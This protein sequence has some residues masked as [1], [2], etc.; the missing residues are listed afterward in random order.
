[1]PST[2]PLVSIRIAAYNHEAFIEQTLDSILAD[3]YPNKEIVIIND[4]SPDHTG[5]IIQKWINLHR[6]EIMV[7]YLSR[8]NRGLTKTINELLSMCEGTYICGVA[9]DDYLLEGGIAKRVSYLE[10]HPEKF[11]VIGDC[12]VVNEK[13]EIIFKSAL[14]DYY[15]VNKNNYFTNSGL[16]NEI[17]LH[18]AIPGPVLMVRKQL[19]TQTDITYNTNLIVEDWDMYLK[20]V[21]KNLLG[22][23]DEPV[24]A[25]RLH[26]NNLSLALKNKVLYDRMFTIFYNIR[27]F[28]FSGKVKLLY[29]GMQLM[30]IFVR[31]YLSKIKKIIK[32]TDEDNTKV[33]L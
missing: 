33:S 21:S 29:T 18:W 9:S 8:E 27:H 7:K 30:F 17:I 12:I 14:S 1:M 25:Y 4:G 2:Y 20:L 15:K 32:K 10:S 31:R 11:A 24:S 26:Q 13:N 16:R 3:S 22:F 5:D 6:H 19:Y 28:D 23:T